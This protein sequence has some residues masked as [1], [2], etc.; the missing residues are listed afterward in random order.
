MLPILS[1]NTARVLEEDYGIVGYRDL[2]SIETSTDE[3]LHHAVTGG[4]AGFA[5]KV[6]LMRWYNSIIGNPI[7]GP[8]REVTY[9]KRNKVPIEKKG[10]TE[11]ADAFQSV[12]LLTNVK[13]LADRSGVSEDVAMAALVAWRDELK[14][15]SLDQDLKRDSNE[16]FFLL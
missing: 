1:P 6:P 3:Q 8:R 15:L 10:F 11:R 13:S 4:C 12:F 14:K 16:R 5:R 9:Q 7:V 2:P